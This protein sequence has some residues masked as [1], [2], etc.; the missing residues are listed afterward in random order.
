MSELNK[1]TL[2]PSEEKGSIKLTE[3][4]IQALRL[5]YANSNIRKHHE[6]IESALEKLQANGGSPEVDNPVGQISEHNILDVLPGLKQALSI[7]DYNKHRL[8]L[9]ALLAYDLNLLLANKPLETTK[10]QPNLCECCERK[11]IETAKGM[12]KQCSEYW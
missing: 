6:L 10:E 11:P 1:K 3:E 4:E 5:C 12:C 9:Y 8:Q 2:N 7:Y